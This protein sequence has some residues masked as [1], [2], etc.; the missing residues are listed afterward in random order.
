MS[1]SPT[2][3][4]DPEAYLSEAWFERE[5]RELFGR[6]W[7]F[8]GLEGDL[9]APGD[10][11]AVQAGDTPVV[12]VR[13]KDGGLRAYHNIC[14]H[15]GARLVEGTGNVSAGLSCFYHRWHYNLDGSL[16]G[17][18]Q[19]EQFPA[20][21]ADKPR[22]GLN[23]ASVGSWNG[24]IFVNAD[25]A[26]EASLMQ[27][28]DRVPDRWGPWQ[29]DTLF[30]LPRSEVE[31]EAN[32]KLFIEN[33]I[34]GYHLAHLHVKSVIGLD[35]A[36]QRWE[37]CGRHWMFYEPELEA[38]S[39]PDRALSGLPVIEGVDASR[40]G[41]SV[42][43]L[44]PN[45]GGAGGVTF[46]SIFTVDPLSAQRTRVKF[47]TFIKPMVEQDFIDD[48]DL[49]GRIEN[50]QAGDSAKPVPANA[51]FVERLA[52]AGQERNFVAEDKL[53]VEAIQA[54]LRSRH[55]SVGALAQD[56]EAAIAF[57]QRNVIAGLEPLEAVR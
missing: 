32:W 35:H 55:F 51:T 45:I 54:S 56:F 18:P 30:E 22:F 46:F 13:Q 16:R 5:Q 6:S 27:W 44:F 12:V 38:G 49:A 15:R 23:P 8:A 21:Q 7:L 53:A 9:P 40:Y 42:F 50:S 1:D 48:P 47:R 36:Q 52:L 2:Y 43:M 57:F 31:V 28:L 19:A 17:I 14:R 3:L 4:L 41:S 10:Y 26:P 24:M 20:V 25:P 37:A 39:M 33:H 34:D 11:V 29:P